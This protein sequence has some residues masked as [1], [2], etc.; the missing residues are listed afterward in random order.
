MTTS[1][2]KS[3]KTLV[4]GCRS[5]RKHDWEE[6]IDRLSPA[7]FS[8]CYRFRLWRE[9]SFD[10]FGKVSLLLLENLDNVRHD[11]RIFGYVSAIAY[12]EASAVKA[13]SRLFS[14]GI[15][16]ETLDRLAL[17]VTAREPLDFET[18]DEFELMARAYA[19]LSEK[20]QELLRLLF[21]E[22]DRFS[23]RDIS[24]KMNIPVP[25]IGPTRARCLEKLRRNMIAE[26][27]EK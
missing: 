14:D 13:G 16:D 25:S 9:E 2:G 15:N 18:E 11:E 6:L 3:I 19:Q 7:I 27:Y 5:G 10:V 21:L 1:K 17:E 24:R 4:A 8:V 23:Y 12:H 20:C 26:G 22:G